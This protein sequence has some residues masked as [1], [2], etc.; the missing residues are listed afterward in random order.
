MTKE[1]REQKEKDEDF[2]RNF[3]SDLADSEDEYVVLCIAIRKTIE[4]VRQNN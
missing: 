1:E 3:A 4:Y 2:I